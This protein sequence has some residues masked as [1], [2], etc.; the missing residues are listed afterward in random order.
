MNL[1]VKKLQIYQTFTHQVLGTNLYSFHD[2]NLSLQHINNDLIY[3]TCRLLA[4]I[5]TNAACNLNF[6]CKLFHLEEFI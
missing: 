6:H 3:S 1:R 2:F 4:T 5:A